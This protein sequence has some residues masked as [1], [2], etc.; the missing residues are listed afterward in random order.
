MAEGGGAAAESV[1]RGV[2]T[3]AGPARGVTIRALICGL[4][5]AVAVNLLANTMR[6]VQ[7][8]SYMAISLIPMG[9]LLLF[10]L[11]VLICAVLARW[12]GRRFVLAPAE[13][14]TIFSMGLI[15]AMGPTYG[16]S[17]YLVSQMVAPYYFATPEN[18]W[19]EY[20]HPH[21]PG[22]LISTDESRALTLFFEGL[23][24]GASIPW[25][26]WGGPLL[27][28]F[29]FVAALGF[30]CFCVSVILHRQWADHEK[31]VYPA[32]TPVLEM[33]NRAGTG[34]RALP[35]FMKGKVFWAGFAL[36]SA[37]FWLNMVHWFY[38]A[39]PKVMNT[40]MIY[41]WDLLSKQYPPFCVYLSIFLIC[42]SYFAS[43][44]VLFSIWFFDILYMIEAGLLNRVGIVATSPHYGAGPYN[45]TSYKF[46][47]AGA[48][49]ALVLWWI[50]ISRGHLREVFRKARHPD[51]S[52]LDDSRELISYR[53][54]VIGLVVCCVYIAA[55]LG[56]VGIEAGMIAV[57]MPA[58]FI[59]Y[60]G[61]AKVM[62]DSGLVYIDPPAVAWDY[63]LFVLG[64]E[65]ALNASTNAA[66]SLLS[67]TVNHP[68]SFALPMIAQVNRLGDFVPEG[69][70]RFFWGIF[71]AFVV[72]MV[73]S[74]LHTI[75]LAYT[76]GG[77]NF[78]P[79]WLILHEGEWQYGMAVN[80]LRNPRPILTVEY[81]LFLA[82]IGVMTVLN[83]MRYRF[84]WWRLHPVG[85]ALSGT[86]FTRL[87]SMTLLVAWLIKFLMIKIG[88]VA[89]Y[90]RS[91]PFFI[92]ILTGYIVAVIAGT[93]V[94]AI[95]FPYAGHRVHSWH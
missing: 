55:W 82:G 41:V 80:A 10:L 90:R 39:F 33:T 20:L 78:Q 21:L 54:A 69:K 44:D 25:E 14:I 18:R 3:E 26:A 19:A 5:L 73:V 35:E 22:W 61:V 37:V 56:Q 24:K 28:W 47:T 60:V 94:D 89:F 27:W 86:I 57:L 29:S 32:L 76:M 70:R 66:F 87:E 42:F 45:V 36:T 38:P 67:F 84:S 15:S 79:N 62:A 51:R 46:Q 95:W 85:F 9:D 34:V 8:G 49:A 74:T 59:A 75:W 31:L 6:Y 93:V 53:A 77:Y 71:G 48:F 81:W 2:G 7:R 1:R 88:G 83:L 72:G 16:I 4:G 40:H 13:W 50:W 12:F 68:R 64:G 65:R 92:G 91:M 30:A 58:M 23:P 63:S 17:G 43:L 11:L 52:P